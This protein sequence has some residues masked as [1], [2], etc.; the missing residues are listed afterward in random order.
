MREKL[1]APGPE[2]R[3]PAKASRKVL[4]SSVVAEGNGG[5]S[6]FE[7]ETGQKQEWK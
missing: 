1:T 7:L 2:C 3:D 4:G 6:G 5:I